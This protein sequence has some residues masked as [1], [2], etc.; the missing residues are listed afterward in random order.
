MPHPL[1]YPILNGS[2]AFT[3]ESGGLP[4]SSCFWAWTV[5]GKRIVVLVGKD[6]QHDPV[7]GVGYLTD[8]LNE[9]ECGISISSV[10]EDHSGWWSCFLT[11]INSQVL[12]GKVNVSK[13][14]DI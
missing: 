5:I 7:D 11:A 12:V 2:A 8:G 10:N 9:G 13:G 4:L 6:V 3:C 14:T 1:V